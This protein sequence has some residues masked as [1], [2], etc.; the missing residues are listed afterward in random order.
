MLCERYSEEN[1]KCDEQLD[2][3]IIEGY[4]LIDRNKYTDA[5]DLWLE[6]WDYLKQRFGFNGYKDIDKAGNDFRGEVFLSNWVQDIEMNLHNAVWMTKN[7]LKKEL[8]FAK[9]FVNYYL[10]LV[11]IY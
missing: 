3:I 7:I 9:N 5:C 2:D 8:N 6:V 11:N 1:I 10:N 4:D